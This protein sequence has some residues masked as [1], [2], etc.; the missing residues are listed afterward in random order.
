MRIH[1][2]KDQNIKEILCDGIGEECI[3][4]NIP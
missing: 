4:Y 1:Y 3:K 2:T